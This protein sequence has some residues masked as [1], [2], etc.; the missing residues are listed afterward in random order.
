[1][2]IAKTTKTAHQKTVA[3]GLVQIHRR[4]RLHRPRLLL[5]AE[6]VG[7]GPGNS[8]GDPA[9]GVQPISTSQ[10]VVYHSVQSCVIAYQFL[11]W[12]II[13]S[14]FSVSVVIFSW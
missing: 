7:R 2:K 10:P 11:Y 13:L 14:S 8:H 1:M 9:D 12:D 4:L 5:L 6:A 3:T